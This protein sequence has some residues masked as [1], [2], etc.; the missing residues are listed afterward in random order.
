MMVFEQLYIPIASPDNHLAPHYHQRHNL[1]KIR[2]SV[3]NERGD[4]V[5]AKS[6]CQNDK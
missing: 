6:H 4:R 3:Q 2:T 1:K 5:S